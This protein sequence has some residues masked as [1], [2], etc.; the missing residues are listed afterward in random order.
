MSC[1]NQKGF[2]LIE[3]IVVAG[4]I[5]IL[6]G[7]LVPMIFGQIDE[8]KISRAKADCDTMSKAIHLFKTNTGKWPMFSA[9]TAPCVV[10][11]ATVIDLLTS[12]GPLPALDAG[13]AGWEF[14][15]NTQQ[16]NSLLR[17]KDPFTANGNGCYPVP[18]S[19]G[20]VGWK[21]PYLSSF[22]ET[23]PWG[24]AYVIYTPD[25]DNTNKVYVLSAGPDGIL[26][27]PTSSNPI[28]DDIGVGIK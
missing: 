21:G 9:G 20:G 23:D 2:T 4:I 10:G 11:N 7:I 19:P 24:N 14:A 8:S 5:A 17:S 28:N 12:D 3:V 1:R 27:T 6:A 26:Q 18:A 15:G 25:F 16:Y 22:G 13:A